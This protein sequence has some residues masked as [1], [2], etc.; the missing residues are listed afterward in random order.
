VFL[1]NYKHKRGDSV[2]FDN[3]SKNKMPRNN[4]LNVES[5]PKFK[6]LHANDLKTNLLSINQLYDENPYVNFDKEKCFVIDRTGECVISRTRT[7]DNCY[8]VCTTRSYN[9]MMAKTDEE[10]VWHPKLGHVNYKLLHKR[11]QQILISTTLNDNIQQQ[12]A[13][14]TFLT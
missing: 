4:M 9:C 5:M 10:E 1:V 3:G 13:T 11:A 6:I 2:T 8:Q 7:L 12:L 14:T